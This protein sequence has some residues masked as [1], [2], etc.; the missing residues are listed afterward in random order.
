MTTKTNFNTSRASE[1][2]YC[3]DWAKLESSR[4]NKPL[5]VSFDPKKGGMVYSVAELMAVFGSYRDACAVSKACAKMSITGDRVTAPEFF[6]AVLPRVRGPVADAIKHA[7]FAEYVRRS[8]IR[9]ERHPIVGDVYAI[10]DLMV[11]FGVSHNRGSAADKWW[12]CK[13][14]G[15]E[16]MSRFTVHCAN[17]GRTDYCTKDRFFEN[18]LT[19]LTKPVQKSPAAKREQSTVDN[20][21]INANKAKVASAVHP[22]DTIKTE[23]SKGDVN[24][25]L[26]R[27]KINAA[28]EGQRVAS[29]LKLKIHLVDILRNDKDALIDVLNALIQ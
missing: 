12:R 28:L 14:K 20:K 2:A 22:P 29:E 21:R 6:S 27:M 15:S 1:V 8:G 11:A 24:I 18:I 5:G 7:R 9:S 10:A 16:D 17:R 19:E 26:E 23:E 4:T 25:E 13:S 3:I